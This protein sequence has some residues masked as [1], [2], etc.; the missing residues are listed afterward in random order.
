[1]LAAL[2]VLWASALPGAALGQEP[3]AEVWSRSGQVLRLTHPVLESLATVVIGEPEAPRE[4][5]RRAFARLEVM[6]AGAG[7]STSESQ[8][9]GAKKGWEVRQARYALDTLTLR[10]GATE[11]RIPLATVRMLV[12][13]RELVADSPLPPHVAAT[14]F[15]YAAILVL[16]DGSRVDGDY[17]NLGA[18]VLRGYTREG[19]VEIS[20]D[21]IESIRFGP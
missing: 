21:E 7:T 11:I 20:W 19:R 13:T 9:G 5:S 14:H 6:G 12:L 18:T 8:A 4:D 3:T 17:I 15:R 2:A 1:M 16:T 10:Q